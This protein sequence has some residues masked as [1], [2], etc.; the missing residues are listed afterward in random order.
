M[1]AAWIMDVVPIETRGR[2]FAYREKV[3]FGIIGVMTIIL[4]RVLD[5]QKESGMEMQGFMMVGIVLIALAFLNIYAMMNI[6]DV[7]HEKAADHEPFARQLM[8]PFAD[9][10]F[11]RTVIFYVLWNIALFIGAPFIAVYM[12]EDLELSYTYMMTMNVIGIIVRVLVTG[13]WGVQADRKSWFWSGKYSLLVLAVAICFGDL[14]H[15]QTCG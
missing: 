5:R 6:E 14:S 11:R 1:V 4:G 3:S 8:R 13:M 12:V 9:R 7:N 10:M 2:F 15:L